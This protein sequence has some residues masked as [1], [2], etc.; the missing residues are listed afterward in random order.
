MSP[1]KRKTIAIQITAVVLAA[2]AAFVVVLYARGVFD[3][4]FIDRPERETTA[5]RDTSDAPDPDDTRE[6]PPDTDAP[7][8]VPAPDTETPEPSFPDYDAA[9]GALPAADDAVR[10]GM[11]LYGGLY[12]KD[13]CVLALV[14]GNSFSE[15]YALRD[16][17]TRVVV[18]EEAGGAALYYTESSEM[19]PRPVLTPYFGYLLCDDGRNIKLL[20]AKGKTLLGDISEYVPTGYRDL[21][22][23]PLFKKD[24]GYFYY[25]DGN[26]PTPGTVVADRITW[27]DVWEFPADTLPGAYYNVDPYSEITPTLPESAGM[28]ECTVDENYFNGLALNSSY[29]SRHG[30]AEVFR[31]CEH[32]VLKTVV[33]QPEIDARSA[34]IAAYRAGV[35]DGTVD[36]ST[37]E[38]APIEPV[39]L[40]EDQGFFWG[41]VDQNGDY[42]LTPQYARAYDFPS[43]GPAAI[44]DPEAPD[45]GRLCFI[46]RAGNVRVNAY[47]NTFFNVEL[48]N[49]RVR[50]G[51]YLPDTFGPEN[52][53]MLTFDH[54]LALVR[55]RVMVNSGGRVLSESNVLINTEGKIFNLPGGYDAVAYS[56]GMILLEKDGLYGYMDHTGRW[57]VQPTLTYAQPFCEGLAAA[58]YADGHIGMID[59]G[60]NVVL[61]M[62]FDQV[63][64]A[65]DGTVAAF[66]EGHGWTIFNK[67][68]RETYEEP[69]NP[70]LTI[71]KRLLAEAAYKAYVTENGLADSRN[72]N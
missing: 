50:D 5:P 59:R 14:G 60:G 43:D 25:Y 65:S 56:D 26:G 66:S 22:G 69:V 19:K 57:V 7:D 35:A 23:H 52:T 4:S 47:K 38:P 13:A 41:Y 9:V 63:S 34:E 48:G 33:N 30:S 61:P 40:E 1:D 12:D 28:V 27:N 29:E 45:K 53:G 71:K 46:D 11:K 51:H 18:R 15:H 21:S 31:F 68:S 42:L 2:L 70:I 39:F 10:S 67:L 44:S 36:P 20:D 32:R 54:G 17:P 37:P 62:V 24:G 58:G 49:V 6:D 3:I 64:S 55:R 16:A 72:V 8:T